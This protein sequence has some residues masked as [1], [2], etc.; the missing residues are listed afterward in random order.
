[1]VSHRYLLKSQ[2]AACSAHCHLHI[3]LS[4]IRQKA[5][6]ENLIAYA[7]DSARNAPYELGLLA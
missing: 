7:L 3:M 1:M 4:D 5:L 2:N 6:A